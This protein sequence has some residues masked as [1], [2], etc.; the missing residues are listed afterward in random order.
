MS[1]DDFADV[2]AELVARGFRL[3]F[4]V[5]CIDTRGSGTIGAFTDGA[6]ETFVTWQD[7]VVPPYHVLIVDASGNAARVVVGA[8]GEREVAP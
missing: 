1:R 5:G 3:P 2:V 4:T 7:D 6:S 8:D